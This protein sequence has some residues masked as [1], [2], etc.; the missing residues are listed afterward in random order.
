MVIALKTSD[1]R[2]VFGRLDRPSIILVRGFAM[3]CYG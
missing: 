1:L 3:A 2:W